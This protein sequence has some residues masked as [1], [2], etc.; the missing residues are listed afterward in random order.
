MQERP[1]RP[2][3]TLESKVLLPHRKDKIKE[4]ALL[5]G[6]ILEAHGSP[7][8]T[9]CL[10]SACAI[11]SK[12]IDRQRTWDFFISKIWLQRVSPFIAPCVVALT[13]RM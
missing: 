10:F 3:V 9:S 7:L 5:S 1:W 8:S 11:V 13:A 6:D 2:R 12:G 4:R